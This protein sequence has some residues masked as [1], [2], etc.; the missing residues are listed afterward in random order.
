[1]SI[2]FAKFS[3]LVREKIREK[4]KNIKKGKKKY[5]KPHFPAPPQR[6]HCLLEKLKLKIEILGKF[7]FSGWFSRLNGHFFVSSLF[8]FSPSSFPAPK[9]CKKVS[10]NPSCCLLTL[11]LLLLLFFSLFLSFS[12][13]FFP[14]FF[15]S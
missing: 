15:F 7:S 14:F 10:L 13:F 11:L 9:N 5:G 3:I 4:M 8:P 1:L 12:L 6:H 2:V